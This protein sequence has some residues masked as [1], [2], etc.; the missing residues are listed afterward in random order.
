MIKGCKQLQEAFKGENLEYGEKMNSIKSENYG[1][2]GIDL[3]D[4]EQM[5]ARL[6]EQ[7][8]DFT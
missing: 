1:L 2:I 4:T 7:G 8:V 6:K 5:D 3:T